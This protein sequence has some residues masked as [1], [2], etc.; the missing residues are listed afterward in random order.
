MGSEIRLM[1][2][3][4]NDLEADQ[5]LHKVCSSLLKKG[6]QPLLIGRKLPISKSLNRPYAF[7]RFK[8]WFNKG[9]LFYLNYNLRLFFYLLFTKQ[10]ILIANDLDTLPANFVI[11]K[12][13]GLPLVYDSHELFTEVPEL[14]HRP[15]VKK[16]WKTIERFVLPQIEY[17][18]TVSASIQKY[19]QDHYGLK[20]EVIRN[21][22]LLKSDFN[23]KKKSSKS[24]ILYQ[25]S[26]NQDR[27][28]EE[29]I[30]AMKFLPNKKLWIAG[31][32]D[33]EDQLR[34]LVK[35]NKQE[36][37]IR[38]LG[39]LS[40]D[41]LRK[42]GL[43]AALGVSLEKKEALNYRYALPNK[44]FDYI[45]LGIPVLYADLLEVK[46]CLKGFDVGEVLKTHA[47]EALAKQIEGMLHA[48]NYSSRLV[49]CREAAK[50]LNWQFEESKLF[51]LIEKALNQD[52]K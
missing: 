34:Q 28:L 30:E 38:F 16:I 26:I 11:A 47:A 36:S 8:L 17:A 45:H 12:M 14:L 35:A 50:K 7:K 3:V 19:Y 33:L 20:M 22:P 44:V 40:F 5:R 32:G 2:S 27:G 1:L 43:K 24:V 48:E 9:P 37:Q 13:K 41:E 21:F 49:N 52:E 10:N 4:T 42:V 46:N 29:L 39:R 23:L 15:I 25:G 18:S 31:S 51:Q 6:Y